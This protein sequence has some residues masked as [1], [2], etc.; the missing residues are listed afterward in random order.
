MSRDEG[1][2]SVIPRWGYSSI[3]EHDIR[4]V[5][6]GVRFPVAPPSRIV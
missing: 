4:N 6:I 5:K 1:M 2:I 3:V